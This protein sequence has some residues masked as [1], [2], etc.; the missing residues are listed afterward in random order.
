MAGRPFWRDD[1]GFVA[2]NEQQKEELE[3][4]NKGATQIS[5]SDRLALK[6]MLTGGKAVKFQVTSVLFRR[7]SPGVRD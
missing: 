3:G 2:Q 6:T 4:W 1:Q 5:E 7:T